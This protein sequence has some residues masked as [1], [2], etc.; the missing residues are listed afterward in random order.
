M[1]IAFSHPPREDLTISSQ[2]LG[3]LTTAYSKC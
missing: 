2:E 3:S 1:S